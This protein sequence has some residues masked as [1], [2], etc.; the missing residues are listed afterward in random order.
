MKLPLITFV[1]LMTVAIG[2]GADADE[3]WLITENQ[4]KQ[5]IGKFT[6]TEVDSLR[7]QISKIRLPYEFGSKGSFLPPANMRAKVLVAW[8]AFA[9]DARGRTGGLIE[10]YWLNSQAVL[11]ITQIYYK[12]GERG[13]SRVEK[14]VIMSASEAYAPLPSNPFP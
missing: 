3:Y 12:Q 2:H 10:D 13:I 9:S 8:D 5:F 1:L 4:R 6:K 14:L 11:R 7:E